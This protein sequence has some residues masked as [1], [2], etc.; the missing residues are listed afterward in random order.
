MST[1]WLGGVHV[2]REVVTGVNRA[3]QEVWVEA[4]AGAPGVE[5]IAAA[6]RRRDIEV[7]E[8]GTDAFAGLPIAGAQH[9]AARCGPF[10]YRGEADLPAAVPERRPCF[11]V[12]LDH[13]QDPQNLGAILRTA[14]VAG[15]LAA[16]LP[17]RRAAGITPAVVRAS[18]GASEHLPVHAVANVARAVERLKELGYWT[19][20]LDAGADAAWDSVDYR[21]AV[22]IV[23][24]AEGAGLQRL[25]GERCDHLVA[26]PVV[27]RVASLNASA[28]FA[29]LAYEVVR[30]QL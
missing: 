30:Q 6:A 24:G 16:V 26:L 17:K 22:G 18:A 11:V 21:G 10:R 25:V 5:E 2:V 12:V 1:I 9:V 27:G 20:G 15:A 29:A 28:A 4:G 19:V 7:R 3:V 13:L 23:V 14:E 8:M